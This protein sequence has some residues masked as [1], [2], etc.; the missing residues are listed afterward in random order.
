MAAVHKTLQHARMLI[1]DPTVIGIFVIAIVGSI[2]L[3]IPLPA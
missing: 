1:N 2:C 3:L